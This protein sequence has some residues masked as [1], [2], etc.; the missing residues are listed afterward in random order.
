MRCEGHREELWAKICF[1]SQ[2]Q[3]NLQKV[4]KSA[5]WEKIRNFGYLRL[6]KFW[7]LFP[8]TNFYMGGWILTCAST[9]YSVFT[10]K[11]AK[12]CFTCGKINCHGKQLAKILWHWFSENFPLITIQIFGTSPI[13]AKNRK[14]Y[15]KI[16][17]QE[18]FLTSV[19][20]KIQEK[21]RK[22]EN[23]KL[24]HNSFCL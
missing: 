10:I 19:F 24:P 14:R 15:Q 13:V 16:L 5:K 9:K 12:Y 8:K 20:E 2:S 23:L 21:S 18:I 6:C 3:S 22:F 7:A 4:R 1:H 11:D 17:Y